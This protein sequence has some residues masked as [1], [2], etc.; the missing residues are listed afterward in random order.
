MNGNYLP[1]DDDEQTLIRRRTAE[2]RQSLDLGR[3]FADMGIGQVLS[4]P[5]SVEDISSLVS[6]IDDDVA[7]NQATLCLLT[8]ELNK[9]INHYA[10]PNRSRSP[11]RNGVDKAKIITFNHTLR[12]CLLDADKTSI[13]TDEMAQRL[14]IFFADHI[15]T[16]PEETKAFVGELH[17]R[18]QG[19]YY[20]QCFVNYLCANGIKNRDATIAE[21]SDGSDIIIVIDGRELDIDVKASKNSVFEESLGYG[22]GV[23]VFLQRAKA[24]S[25]KINIVI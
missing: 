21:D 8:P 6:E 2:Y 3:S 1:P 13:T 4:K 14:M 22:N 7:R 23:Y 11:W 20:E 15:S 19:A 5:H 24:C 12:E 25:K 10:G 17:T 16:G 18:I 9:L